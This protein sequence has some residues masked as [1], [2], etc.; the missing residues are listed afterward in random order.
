MMIE[1]DVSLRYVSALLLAGATGTAIADESAAPA[2]DALPFTLV[3]YVEG[4][5]GRAEMVL[6]VDPR[7]GTVNGI[8]ATVN[9]GQISQTSESQGNQYRTI[10][11]RY[12]G[13]IRVYAEA[14]PTVQVNGSRQLAEAPK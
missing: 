10:I 7:L 11:N 12:S 5:A 14:D 4:G 6:R 9:Y 3:C 13:G 8:P 2:P 1:G